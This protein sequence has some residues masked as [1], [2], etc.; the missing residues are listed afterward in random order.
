[1]E[2]MTARDMLEVGLAADFGEICMR[3]W[4]TRTIMQARM[5][6]CVH[7]RPYTENTYT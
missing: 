1:M 7:Q 5:P 3:S 4:H 6:V 2:A